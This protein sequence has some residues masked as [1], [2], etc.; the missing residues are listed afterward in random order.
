MKRAAHRGKRMRQ[1]S[2]QAAEKYIR[3]AALGELAIWRADDFLIA[4]HFYCHDLR[5]YLRFLRWKRKQ[6]FAREN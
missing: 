2:E 1:G 4:G 6:D 5:K 3:R